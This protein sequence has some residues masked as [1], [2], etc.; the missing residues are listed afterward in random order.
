MFFLQPDGRLLSA[1]K[2]WF[3]FDDEVVALGA[4]IRSTAA[5]N[6]VETIVENRRVP[7]GAVFTQDAAG[8]WAHLAG[9]NIGYWFPNGAGWQTL[10]ETR[11]GAWRDLNAGGS[12]TALT[13]NYR[14]VWFDH[15]IEPA[16][17]GYVY[18]L[19]PGKTAQQTAAYAAAPGVSVLQNDASAQAVAHRKLGIRAVTFWNGGTVGGITSDSI[20]SVI[21]RQNRA[22]VDLAVSD[23]TQTGDVVHLDVAGLPVLSVRADEGI[24]VE[25]TSPGLRLWV[26]VKNA[27]GR[28]FR[29]HIS[30]GPSVPPRR[31]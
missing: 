17:A 27:A 5:G 20:A 12:T 13:A 31:R 9:Q 22:S 16:G 18:V 1:R 6:P 15:G 11:T 19:L 7:A 14:T 10:A 25:R 8:A 26:R 24:T 3:L 29:A 2:S 28:T 30:Q 21:L 23:P 4:D